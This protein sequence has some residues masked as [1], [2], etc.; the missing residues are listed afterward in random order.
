MSLRGWTVQ[1]LCVAGFGWWFSPV[2]PR[3][4][5]VPQ[6]VIGMATPCPLPAQAGTPATP[7]QSSVPSGMAPIRR[8]R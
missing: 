7:L 3:A 5:Y 8:L 6:A 1:L 4:P 2:S